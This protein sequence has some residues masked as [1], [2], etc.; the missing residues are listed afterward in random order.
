MLDIKEEASSDDSD[1]EKPT[2]EVEALKAKLRRAGLE[3][4]IDS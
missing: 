4:A 2:D 3:N 1:G